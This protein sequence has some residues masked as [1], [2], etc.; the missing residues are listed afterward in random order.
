MNLNI[1][2]NRTHATTI[3]HSR[4][5][6]SFS[7][8]CIH[9][10]LARRPRERSS[11]LTPAFIIRTFCSNPDAANLLARART[12]AQSAAA[13]ALQRQNS[14]A[15]GDDEGDE[16]RLARWITS[17]ARTYKRFG[18]RPVVQTRSADQR[19][20]LLKLTV[21]TAPLFLCVFLR[22]APPSS[23]RRW[24]TS[25]ILVAGEFLFSLASA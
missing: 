12:S 18:R 14:L 15:E 1:S 20:V 9:S 22:I 3:I 7:P 2:K 11:F 21:A 16:T 6:R 8:N 10:G 4:A 19:R 13:A 24:E 23:R 25:S 5:S 17:D